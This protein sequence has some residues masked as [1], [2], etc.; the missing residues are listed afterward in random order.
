MFAETPSTSPQTFLAS[1]CAPLGAA[2]EATACV[3]IAA[4][5]LPPTARRLLAHSEHMTSTLASFYGEAVALRVLQERDT[6]VSGYLRRIALF[7]PSSGRV[8]EYGVVWIDFSRLPASVCDEIRSHR[9]PLGEVLIAHNVL[10]RVRP[11]HF[12]HYSRGAAFLTVFDESD[13]GAAYGRLATIECDEQP[14]I[15]LL[16]VVC[17]AC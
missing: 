9:R 15:R 16:E 17:A 10:R 3:P 1:L 7:L 12:V 8:V 4:E 5:A 11:Q 6:G 2:E 14:A 13:R